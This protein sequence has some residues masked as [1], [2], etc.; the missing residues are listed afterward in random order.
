MERRRFLR[1]SAAATAA[2]SAAGDLTGCTPLTRQLSGA[3]AA[4]GDGPWPSVPERAA[5]L[6]GLR[7][8]STGPTLAERRRVAKIGLAGWIEEQL[9]ADPAHDGDLGWRLRRLD[10][11]WRA[12]D[13][14]DG[15][16]P[17]L[18]REELAAV[19]LLRRVYTSQ[20][21]AEQMVEQ[22]V[23]HFNLS[24]D[25]GE[26]W[27]LAPTWDR[28]VPRAHALGRFAD[29]LRSS[30]RAPAMLTYLDNRDSL[31]EAP[32]ENH[33]RELL[34]LHSLGVGG[35]YGQADVRALA[36]ALTGWTVRDRWR[37][38]RFRF[39]ADR[40][41]AGVKLLP[42]LDLELSP[43]AA[44]DG[45]GEA[46]V[47]AVVARLAAHPSTA[48]RVALRLCR[49]FFA[50][51]PERETP[52]A[53]ARTET[54][55]ADSGGDLRA[56]LSSLLL[57]G[58]LPHL[59]AHGSLPPK[60]K[61]PADFVV[62][63]LRVTAAETDGGRAIQSDLSAMGHVPYRWPTPDGPPDLATPWLGGLQ[64][65]WSFAVSV[66]GGDRRGTNVDTAALARDA[67]ANDPATLVERL[68][69]LVHGT[70][71][72]PTTRD[73]IVAA[74]PSDAGEGEAAAITLAALLAAPAFQWR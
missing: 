26:V 56:T 71:L 53:L 59:E 61:R 64:A 50:D 68:S 51:D 62:S 48:R 3:P 54:A 36:R 12:P 43:A 10:T 65:R 4:L 70:P 24:V 55:F 60:L 29:L 45:T 66:V 67:D 33:A 19:T 46:E 30:V 73:A 20:P 40:H 28:E 31:P 38:D 34:E 74:L 63:A 49:R 37:P 47:E 52:E 39:D 21:L 44:L 13:E 25:K 17:R 14:L 23:D 16:R 15:R 11:P 42:G 8:L 7:R 57:D 22:W 35:G 6:A 32:N 27:R 5:D 72:P 1:L 9:A 58:L 69:T 18:V 41:D 2:T